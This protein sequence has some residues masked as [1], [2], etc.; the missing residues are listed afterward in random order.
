MSV[1]EEQDVLRVALTGRIDSGNAA[2]VEAEIGVLLARTPRQGL[3]LDLKELE[4]MSSAGLRVLLRLRKL[5]PGLRLVNASAEV[6]EILNLT[7]FTEMIPVEKAYRTVSIQGCEIIGR[8]SIGTVYRIDEDTAVK[9]YHGDHCLADVQRE[10][11]LARKAFVLGV[12]TAIPYDVVR[13]GEGNGSVFELLNAHSFS[14]LIAAD[15]QGMDVY[16]ER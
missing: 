16:V 9:V 15:P 3:V 10:R 1:T 8:G 7:G 12:P 11:E 5:E 14:K 13:V 2:E 6:Y 4:Y